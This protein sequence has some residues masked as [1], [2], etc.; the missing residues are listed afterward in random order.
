MDALIK[1]MTNLMQCS[2]QFNSNYHI[3]VSKT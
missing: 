1:G 2:K 3:F